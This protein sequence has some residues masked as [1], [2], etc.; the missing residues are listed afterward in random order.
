M[1][2][3]CIAIRLE[4]DGQLF[5]I[6]RLS[7]DGVIVGGET[8]ALPRAL[9]FRI[10]W[11]GNNAIARDA[12]RR[13]Q[14]EQGWPRHVF[15]LHAGRRN[16][17][18]LELSGV[19]PDALPPTIYSIRLDIQG[20]DIH[21]RARRIRV[22]RGATKD[23]TFEVSSNDPRR[24]SRTRE[25]DQFDGVIARFFETTQADIDGFTLRAWTERSLLRESR[26]A[27]LF[28]LL[29]KLRSIDGGGGESLLSRVQRIRFADIDRI[30]AAVERA[31]LDDLRA[32]TV[33]ANRRFLGE[34]N[35][36]AG[37]HRKLLD[38][39]GEDGGDPARYR[40]RDFRENNMPG[41]QCVVAVPM[42]DDWDPDGPSTIDDENRDG[43]HYADIDID[44]G[45]PT[46]DLVGFVVHMGE[47]A[48]PAATDHFD[49]LD[50][51]SGQDDVRPFVYYEIIE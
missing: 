22:E 49:L 21:S 33:G 4:K 2:G 1:A 7:D 46:R 47:L 24:F 50:A 30:H 12:I 17:G 45:V 25:Y 35:V 20:F 37:I 51:L 43:P 3:E 36:S 11:P 9:G 8:S 38:R 18:V 16:D 19:A 42:S 44:E 15:R 29:A 28:N 48:S 26:K 40:L 5:P 10:T 34:T 41:L 13:V 31:F 6:E 39:V 32:H 23:V 27:C 14:A